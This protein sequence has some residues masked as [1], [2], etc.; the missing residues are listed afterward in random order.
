MRMSIR[1]KIAATVTV[2]VVAS[3]LI[4]TTIS[5]RHELR[6]YL[7]SRREALVATAHAFA[8]AAAE[9]TSKRNA[10]GVFEALKAIGDVPRLLNATARDENGK[11]LAEV[12]SAAR[13][14]GDA[15]VGD[16]TDETVVALLQS[17]SISAMVPILD[18]GTRIGSLELVS[19]AD[20]LWDDVLAALGADAVGTLLALAAALAIAA[21]L[22]HSI[23]KPL[24]ALTGI[25][26]HV[27][28]EHDYAVSMPAP[29]GDEVGV[30]I[31]G[32]NTMLGDIRERG[33]LLARH[34]GRLEQDIEER[35]RDLALATQAAEEAN[36]AKS[37]FL[38]TMSHEI[39]TPMTG[40]L[41]MAELLV[42]GDLPQKSRRYAEVISKS[43]Q[44]LLAIINDILDFSKIEA[45][46]LDV[47]Q[48]PVD[49]REVA[50]TVVG[51]FHAR[52]SD[53][54]LDLAARF[55]GDLPQ[56]FLIDPVR[57]QQV[58]GN[59]VNNA[60]KFTEAGSVLLD[61]RATQGGT[62]SFEVTDTG[63]GIEEAR[64]PNVFEAFSQADGTTTRRFGGTGLGLTIS[65]R[66]AEAMGGG[67]TVRSQL[68][69]GSTFSC[70]VPML[71]PVP[72]PARRNLD[73]LEAHVAVEGAATRSAA[74]AFLENAGCTVRQ[75]PMAEVDFGTVRL[76]L[77]DGLPDIDRARRGAA[78]VVA[79]AEPGMDD[80]GLELAV[81]LVLRKPLME[82]ELLAVL[83]RITGDEPLRATT[84]A[85]RRSAA[86]VAY[87]ARVLV[88]DDTAVNREVMREALSRFGIHPDFAED[89]REALEA[90]TATAYDLV[91]M[92]G[93]MPELDG[94]EACRRLRVAEAG[95]G[96][97][98]VVIALTA[99]AV[100]PSA[101]AWV[102]AGMEGVL[103]K[104]FTI[105]ELTR[106][107]A[108]RLSGHAVAEASPGPANNGPF[109][110][111]S[112]IG[113]AERL[114]DRSVL[115]DMASLGDGS[116]RHFIARVFGLYRSHAPDCLAKARTAMAN[117]EGGALASASHALKSM[118]F[119]IGAKQVAGLAGALEAQGRDDLFDVDALGRLQACL[120]AT[121]AEV[122][123]VLAQSTPVSGAAAA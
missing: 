35:T 105:A 29:G 52:A 110:I 49:P 31:A 93:S 10:D 80:A 116:G 74:I 86:S 123:E 118:S 64:L 63:I 67:L 21:R 27:S 6:R 111:A 12:G 53:K 77:T 91:F 45:G 11:V 15:V 20:D 33:E 32:F 119:N 22:Q 65:T 13:L 108:T 40:L 50:N 5:M 79:L 81:D 30:L 78:R 37:T 41:V 46:K 121:L 92:D 51:L 7:E 87:D 117:R 57:L 8:S 55:S 34:R 98:T 82:D 66:L 14:D 114:I 48:L 84:V 90:A 89:G 68:G 19:A 103:Y 96:R 4:T 122:D 70:T 104:P 28:A 100:G 109:A 1:R 42:T 106:C 88:A 113:H 2:A 58:V 25:M 60:L 24:T 54:G 94:F 115:D 39:R 69:V 83:D 85:A 120:L 95:S 59:L 73:G 23:T 107:L 75:G 3:G 38:A 62:V 112:E 43:G 26:R 56:N 97:H 61:V 76:V 9:P 71:A 99:H 72:P 36:Q 17:R 102:E 44:A 18:S 16:G 47:E 101:N